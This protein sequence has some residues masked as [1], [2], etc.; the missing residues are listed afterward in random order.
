MNSWGSPFNRCSLLAPACAL[1]NWLLVLSAFYHHQCL[2]TVS[3]QVHFNSMESSEG[4]GFT[5]EGGIENS[6]FS[7]WITLEESQTK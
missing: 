4:S 5:L 3:S 1:S 2:V 6:D 7:M